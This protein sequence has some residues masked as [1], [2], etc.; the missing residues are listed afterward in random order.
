MSGPRET[1]IGMAAVPVK[2]WKPCEWGW[3]VNEAE[4]IAPERLVY[5]CPC[6]NDTLF[7]EPGNTHLMSIPIGVD[8]KGWKWDGDWQAP[9]LTPSIKTMPCGWHGYMSS[10]ILTG[11]VDP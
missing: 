2:G 7:H 5:G 4:S 1:F 9:T 11:R 6:G 3:V 8:Q 10:G